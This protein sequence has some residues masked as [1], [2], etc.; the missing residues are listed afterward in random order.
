MK[1]YQLT[2]LT[3]TL[4][5]SSPHPHTL[6][7]GHYYGRDPDVAKTHKLYKTFYNRPHKLDQLA[8]ITKKEKLMKMAKMASLYK[9]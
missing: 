5:E 7:K 2:N 3:Y 9:L 4:S 6:L 8:K 1:D